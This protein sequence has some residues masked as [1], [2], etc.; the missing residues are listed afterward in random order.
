MESIDEQVD[1][2]KVYNSKVEIQLELIKNIRNLIEVCNDRIKWKTEELLPVGIMLKQ[3][4][5]IIK[6]NT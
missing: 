4:D 3:L 1:N 5:D 6:N 2:I